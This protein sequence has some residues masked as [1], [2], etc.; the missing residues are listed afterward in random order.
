[1]FKL[2]QKIPIGVLIMGVLFSTDVWAN[3]IY[4]FSTS[5][6]AP[7]KIEKKIKSKLNGVDLKVFA[8]FSDFKAMIKKK[9]P[10]VA[11]APED[12]LLSLKKGGVIFSPPKEE[13][14]FVSMDKAFD[15]SVE[16]L[17]KVGMLSIMSRSDMKKMLKNN[18]GSNPIRGSK[19][20]QCSVTVAQ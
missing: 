5:L 3:S 9:P 13:L 4:V 15:S 6:E 2:F 11:I 8:R 10:T 19:L 16:P 7:K 20:Y 1:M 18:V 12:A 17:E 14:F